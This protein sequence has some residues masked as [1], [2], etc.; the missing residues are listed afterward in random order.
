MT[1]ILG[2]SFPLV[3][4]GLQDVNKHDGSA[5]LAEQVR[6]IILSFHV[7]VVCTPMMQNLA[8]QNKLESVSCE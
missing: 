4:N 7:E 6:G 3:K 8:T 2:G 5:D 1:S